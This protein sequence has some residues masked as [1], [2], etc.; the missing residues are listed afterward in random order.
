MTFYIKVG[1]IAFGYASAL[2]SGWILGLDYA[3]V[4]CQQDMEFSSEGIR[5]VCVPSP[6]TGE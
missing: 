4:S 6:I 5:Y 1:A 2:I 3:A